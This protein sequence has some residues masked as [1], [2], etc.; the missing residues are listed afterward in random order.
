MLSLRTRRPA[1][2]AALLAL[3]SFAACGGDSD[4]VVPPPASP[5][6]VAVQGALDRP[7]SL[8]VADLQALAPVTQTVNYGSGSG[9]QTHTYTGTNLWNLLDQAGIRVDAARKNDVLGKYVLAT[10]ADGYKAVFALGE[11]KPDFGN[12]ASL[13]VYAETTNG[14]SGALA[15]DGPVRVTA[16]GDVKG[17]RYVSA[18]N[19]HRDSRAGKIG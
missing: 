1:T 9:P 6:V 15:S 7:A 5:K 8:S 4:D 2:V 12:R 13:V 16:P 11:L 10:G 3:V 18:L 14:T 19:L 17:G